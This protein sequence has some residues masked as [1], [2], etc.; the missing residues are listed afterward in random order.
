MSRIPV[1]LIESATGKTAYVHM[2]VC[3]VA[4]GKIPQSLRSRSG[5]WR[6]M[7]LRRC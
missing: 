6:P 4:G 7:C 5:T 3:K 1:P 2:Q